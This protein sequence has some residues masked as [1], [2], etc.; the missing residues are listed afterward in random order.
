M[1]ECLVLLDTLG[2]FCAFIEKL[3]CLLLSLSHI[4]LREGFTG[5]LRRLT[6]NS[7]YVGG[8]FFP[9]GMHLHT[10]LLPSCHLHS[11]HYRN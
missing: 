2:K 7:M 9:S 5:T 1:F 4:G 11:L 8:F 10:V 6:A 3:I